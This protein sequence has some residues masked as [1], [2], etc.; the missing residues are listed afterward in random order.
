MWETLSPLLALQDGYH[1]DPEHPEIGPTVEALGDLDALPSWLWGNSVAIGLSP[2]S[3]WIVDGLG[4]HLGNL[5]VAVSPGLRWAVGRHRIRAYVYQNHP[6]ITANPGHG[7]DRHPV[8]SVGVIALRHLDLSPHARTLRGMYDS[9]SPPGPTDSPATKDR[10]VLAP[11]PTATVPPMKNCRCPRHI[12]DLAGVAVPMV[13][14]TDL[15]PGDESTVTVGDL[16]EWEAIDAESDEDDPN[17]WS[18]WF[19]DEARARLLRRR[20]AKP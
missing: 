13:A 5:L 8:H 1:P 12:E 11:L 3:I 6:V 20:P 17:R 15:E 9:W 18:L 2:E 7:A 19:G 14:S 4:R 10:L 16:L